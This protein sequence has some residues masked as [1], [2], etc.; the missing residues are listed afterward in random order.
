MRALW[1]DRQ[2]CSHDV[3][4]TFKHIKRFSEFQLPL[5]YHGVSTAQNLQERSTVSRK[6]RLLSDLTEIPPPIARQVWQYPCRTMFPVVSQTIAATPALLSFKM[7]Y[8]NP[9]T[10]LTGGVSQT[11]LASAAYRAIGG[12]RAK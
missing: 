3:S 2:N 4:Q 7:A 9:K 1:S 11:K 5:S 10:G 12:C 8:R 6:F